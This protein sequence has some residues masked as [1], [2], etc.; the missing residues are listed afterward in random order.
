MLMDLRETV[1]NSKPLKYSLI[2]LISIP[3]A[4]VGI[5]SYLGG[6][7]YTDAAEVGGVP[8]TSADLDRAYYQQRQR[9]AQMFGGNIPENFISESQIRSQA[10]EQLV[11]SQVVRNVVEEEKFAVGDEQLSRNIRNNPQFQVDGQFDKETYELFLRSRST[12]VP[13][14]EQTMRQD[15]ALAQFQAGIVNSSFSLPQE[16]KRLDALS[17]QTRT[18][19]YVRYSIA[20]AVDGIEVSDDDIKAYFD[21]NAANYQFPQRAKLEYIELD[22]ASIASGVDVSDEDARI[23]YEENKNR[24]VTPESRDASHILL[25]AEGADEIAEKTIELQSIKDRIAAGES[26]ADLA[27]EF[28]DDPGSADSGGSLGQITPGA[29]VAEFEKAVY[30]LGAVDELSD[31]VE[32]QFGVHL[33]K[34]DSITAA[35]GKDFEQVKNEIIATMQTQ[36]ADRQFFDLREQLSEA[37]FNNPD[38]LEVAAEI[39]GINVQTSDW[40]DTDLTE[41]AV[42]A[43]PGLLQAIF[44]DEVLNEGF[45]TELI[46]ISDSHVV[47]ARILEHEG[48]RPKT[49]EDVRETVAETIKRERA[50]EQL[51]ELN[52]T[53]LDSLVAGG[54]V[55]EIAEQSDFADAFTEVELTRQSA[56]LDT[57]LIRDIYALAKPVESEVRAAKAVLPDGDRVVYR[58][59]SV[60]VPEGTSAEESASDSSKPVALANPQLGQVELSALIASLR[61]QT[62]ITIAEQN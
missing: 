22:K 45:N 15:T 7:G 51:D 40:V 18:V 61:E 28:S 1:R 60:A 62:D 5:G 14:F 57:S 11:T 34:L 17:K 59:T 8:I 3:F 21:E 38:S 13:Q 16:T 12:S 49:L 20:K 30:S 42:L 2:T 47:T 9:L 29:M 58:L 50:E 26:F 37:A 44:S 56:T 33:I 48:P 32:T 35:A 52:Q 10:L 31:I 46:E 36:E 53:G 23:F 54:N 39:T 27:A 41:D 43:N 25:T 19:D 55:V 24:Y 4:L 6:G